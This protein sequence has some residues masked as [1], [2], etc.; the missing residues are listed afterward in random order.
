MAIHSSRFD[1]VFPL[2]ALGSIE[3]LGV[4]AAIVLVAVYVQ[5]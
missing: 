2:G 1:V 3:L 4:G 5:I